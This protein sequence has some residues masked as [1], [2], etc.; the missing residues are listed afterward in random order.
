MTEFSTKEH[1]KERLWQYAA[2]KW[3][4]DDLTKAYDPFI[5]LLFGGVSHE[6]EKIYHAIYDSNHQIFNH[7]TEVLLPDYSTQPVP[8]H[9]I[10]ALK[11][12]AHTSLNELNT[13][14]DDDRDLFSYSPAGS[15]DLV[16]AEVSYMANGKDLFTVTDKFKKESRFSFQIG[17]ELPQNVLYIGIKTG[18]EFNQDLSKI[19]LYFHSTDPLAILPYDILP[20]AQIVHDEGSLL[21]NKL[22]EREN[23]DN[24]FNTQ[25]ASLGLDSKINHLAFQYYKPRYIQF[26]LAKSNISYSIP[27]QLQQYLPS[28]A[29]ELMKNEKCIWIKIEMPDPWI[30]YVKSTLCL[31]NC[32]PVINRKL[33]EKRES[34][35]DSKVLINLASKDQNFLAL[36]SLVSGDASYAIMDDENPETDDTL[37][38]SF[39]I[40]KGGVQTMDSRMASTMINHIIDMVEEAG[41]L[42]QS[43]SNLNIFQAIQELKKSNVATTPT[44]T[45]VIYNRPNITAYTLKYWTTPI[46]VGTLPKKRELNTD[47]SAVKEKKGYLLTDPLGGKPEPSIAQKLKKLRY[48]LLSRDRI[49]TEEDIRSFIRSQLHDFEINSIIIKQT[50]IKSENIGLSK[51]WSV[52]LEADDSYKGNPKFIYLVKE[53]EMLINEKTTG[54]IP[55]LLKY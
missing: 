18:N 21:N 34:H 24:T 31:L 41:Q 10:L 12:I 8:A 20:L 27:A 43:P 50:V 29:V 23:R 17:K 16:P 33:E 2:E 44:P 5:D 6:I 7:L 30:P 47:F 26:D 36:H 51:A 15:F 19:N 28:S 13:F 32:I 53:T 22:K 42:D 55:I 1:I 52:F 9:S 38:G 39:Q 46:L 48:G 3:H 35:A 45:L 4:I 49:C 25:M 14:F 11:P 54:L 37:P 40:I